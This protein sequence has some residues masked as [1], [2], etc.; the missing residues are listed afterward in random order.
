M[1]CTRIQHL[2]FRRNHHFWEKHEHRAMNVAMGE[3]PIKLT[4]RLLALILFACAI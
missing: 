3:A 1:H 4:I 2:I